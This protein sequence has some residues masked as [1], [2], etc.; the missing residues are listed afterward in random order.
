LP[1]RVK[2]GANITDS[3]SKKTDYLIIGADAGSKL[4]KARALAVKTLS[5]AE[6]VKM[7][8]E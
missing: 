4:D 6:F 7:L 3:V 8:G 1:S 2:A 5:E